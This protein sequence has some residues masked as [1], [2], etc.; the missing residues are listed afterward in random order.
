[1]TGDFLKEKEEYLFEARIQ[2]LQHH[3]PNCIS[4]RKTELKY[5]LPT[6]LLHDFIIVGSKLFTQP[7]DIVYAH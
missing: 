1:M 2:A 6:D 4:V 7:P 5:N 3:W